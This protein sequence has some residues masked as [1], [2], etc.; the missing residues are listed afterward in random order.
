MD[1]EEK[2]TEYAAL[3]V[4]RGVNV[5]KGKYVLL[6]SDIE[7]APLARLVEEECFKC[8]A[9]DV[10]LVYNDQHASRIRLDNADLNVFE[11]LP[12]WKCE[13]RNYYARKGCVC[14]NIIS[15]DPEIFAGADGEKL[16]ASAIAA[17]KGY[18]EFYDKMDKGGIRWT[19]I[20]YASPAWARKVFPKIK[21]EEDAVAKL[22]KAIFRSV[23]IARAD[24]YKKWAK[25]DRSLTRRAKRL[26]EE[27]F[28][29]L[30]YK[31]SLGT[32]FTVGLAENHI[33][34]G[35]SETCA[36]GVSYFPNMPTEEIFTMPDC[37]KA[38]GVVFSAMPL[39]YQGELID[40]FSLT[41]HEGK[42]VSCT[43]EKGLHA[44]ERLLETD[45]GSRRLGEVALIPASSPIAHMGVLFYNTLFDENASCHLALGASYPDTM[46]DGE[47][48]TE[49]Q[50][51]EKGGNNSANHVDFMIGTKDLEVVG[52]RHDGTEVV[53][54][55]DGEFVNSEDTEPE[56]I[57]E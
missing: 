46:K 16:K 53:I 34:K 31:N 29:F 32:D 28:A 35:G 3:A 41:F 2:L 10:I 52:I 11:R 42:V 5:T 48:Y 8:G 51:Y 57:S 13:Q 25:H 47:T 54:M 44:L 12:D 9:K 26:N 40:K 55:R 38:E 15:E 4:R 1:F 18:K 24:T 23:R 14:I 33:W 21:R 19:I 30:R 37:R 39:S 49:E 7:A 22:W 43:A 45:E 6:Y 27:N 17:H 36:E 56:E 20:A 50:L